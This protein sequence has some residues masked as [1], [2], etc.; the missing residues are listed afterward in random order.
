[1]IFHL[2]LINAIFCLVILFKEFT[3]D[4]VFASFDW[5]KDKKTRGRKFGQ[6]K[7]E[8]IVFSPKHCEPDEI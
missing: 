7:F 4:V 1:M 3:K 8:D 2:L 6:S 5:L